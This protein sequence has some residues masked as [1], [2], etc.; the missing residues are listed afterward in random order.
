MS[1]YYIPGAAASIFKVAV[2]NSKGGSGK[3]M[4]ASN[5]ASWYAIKG[6][7]TALIDFDPQGSSLRWL[8]LRSSKLPTIHGVN[9]GDRSNTATRAWQMRLPNETQR[10]VID[11]PAGV[12]GF[13]LGELVRQCGVIVIPILPSDVDIHAGAGF[14]ADLLLDAHIR[15]AR[16]RVVVVANR[17]KSNTR[18]YASLQRFLSRLE[19]P[20]IAQFSD[21]QTYVHAAQQ[22]LGIGEMRPDRLVQR[23]L[24]Q[25]HRLL[26][27]LELSVKLFDQARSPA[28][29]G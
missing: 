10:V 22:G 29:V 8:N 28:V 4:L 13:E 21:S 7:D 12:R 2:L 25:W 18:I 19:F 17:I 11:T 9:G 27:S 16:T 6:F 20:L 1:I 3:S 15:S 5:L 26:A 23:E 24:A 14:I